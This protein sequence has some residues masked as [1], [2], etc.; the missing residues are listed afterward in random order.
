MRAAKSAD[1]IRISVAV[2]G[3]WRCAARVNSPQAGAPMSIPAI[4]HGPAAGL[5]GEIDLHPTR[6]LP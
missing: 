3:T 1:E 6:T 5:P 4:A 2:S